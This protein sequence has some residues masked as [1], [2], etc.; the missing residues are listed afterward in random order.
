VLGPLPVVVVMDTTL[1]KDFVGSLA[2]GQVQPHTR[3]SERRTRRND[4]A[5]N[6]EVM[7]IAQHSR[8]PVDRETQSRYQ[9]AY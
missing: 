9:S 4:H 2:L 5:Q 8:F 7:P 3:A 1:Y 6:E